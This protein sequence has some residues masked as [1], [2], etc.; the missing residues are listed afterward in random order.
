MSHCASFCDA[1]SCH[2][3]G[4][5]TGPTSEDGEGTGSRSVAIKLCV[6]MNFLSQGGSASRRLYVQRLCW[7]CGPG[8]VAG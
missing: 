4:V 3:A 6:D 7:I 8:E 5:S 2:R 1:E